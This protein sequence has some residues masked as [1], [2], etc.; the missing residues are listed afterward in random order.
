MIF[1]RTKK[2][3]DPAPIPEPAAVSAPPAPPPPEPATWVPPGHFYSPIA[4]LDDLKAR[5]TAVFDA[6]APLPDVDLQPAQQRALWD[7]LVRHAA[8]FTVAATKE[9]AAAAGQRYFADN[10]QFGPG[11]A[12]IYAGMLLEH[13]PKRLIEVGSGFSS[14]LFL[15]INT[16]FFDGAITSTFIEPYPDRL[17]GLLS[18]ADKTRATLRQEPVQAT[19]LEVFGQLEADDVLFVDSTHVAK[20]GSDVNHLFFRVLPSLKPGVLIH[21]HDIFHPFEYPK[22]WFF[23]GNRSWNELYMLRAF[24]MNNARYRVLFFNSWFAHKHPECEN[25]LPNFWKNPGGAFWMR[26]EG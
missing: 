20:A 12:T 16:G 26:K 5:E 6:E 15:D 2:P 9:E 17:L 11:D 4:D 22:E 10:D 19:P 14:A 13:R 25:E 21:F 1:R 3:A 8:R 18:E 23:N 24:M 7:R